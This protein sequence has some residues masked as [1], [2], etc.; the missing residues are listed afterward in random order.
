MLFN[1]HRPTT[2]GMV[3]ARGEH[4][5]VMVMFALLLVPLLLMAGLA[6][7]VGHWY[8]RTSDMRRAADAAALAGVVWLPEPPPSPRRRA[9]ASCRRPPSRSP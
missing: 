4:G 7:D 8:S 1:H 3:R 5:Y 2:V 6:V 9:T